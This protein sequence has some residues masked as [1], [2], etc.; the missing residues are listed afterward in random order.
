MKFF[1]FGNGL[2]LE[3]IGDHASRY[4]GEGLVSLGSAVGGKDN[5]S[6]P[7]SQKQME[8]QVD[9]GSAGGLEAVQYANYVGTTS[10]LV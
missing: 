7:R 1:P 8:I 3:D 6:K 4:L 9:I 5:V 2:K 10:D